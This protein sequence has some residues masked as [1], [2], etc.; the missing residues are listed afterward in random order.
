VHLLFAAA[1][2]GYIVIGIAFQERDLIQSLGKTHA[3]CQACVPALI[4][5]AWLSRR[6][7]GQAT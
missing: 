1:A 6:R 3:D 2:T 4:A 5:G 7:R